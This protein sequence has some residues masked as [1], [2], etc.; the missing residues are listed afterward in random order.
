MTFVPVVTTAT[1]SQPQTGV[2]TISSS[3]SGAN[4]IID[5]TA[6]GSTPFTT[7]TLTTGSHSLLLQLNGYLDYTTTFTIQ[8]DQLNQE[9]YTLSPVPATIIPQVTRVQTTV[10]VTTVP[11]TAATTI[12]LPQTTAAVRTLVTPAVVDPGQAPPGRVMKNGLF[13]E[14]RF[15]G[16][17]AVEPIT[18]TCREPEIPAGPY[19]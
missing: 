6:M 1:P 18:V 17:V 8:P 10:P 19:H 14:M 2:I 15:N 3:P 11:V 5:G 12:R 4:V 13:T 9:S 16:P 7:R